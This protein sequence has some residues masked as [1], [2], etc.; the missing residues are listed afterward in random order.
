MTVSGSLEVDDGACIGGTNSQAMPTAA[1]IA[2]EVEAATPI[3]RRVRPIRRAGAAAT[4]SAAASA[5]ITAGC[6]GG[7][8][9][10]A[11]VASPTCETASGLK[12]GLTSS[13]IWK[14]PRSSLLRYQPPPMTASHL[15]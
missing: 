13:Q 6:A 1:R 9:T 10:A 5:G 12:C 15:A 8:A 11:T 4:I 3:S 7:S 14:S 2:T